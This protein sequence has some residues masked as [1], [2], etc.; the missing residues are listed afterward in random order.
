MGKLLIT[1]GAVTTASRLARMALRTGVK[2][3]VIQTPSFLNSGGCSY[4]I[5]INES[6]FDELD[7]VSKKYN[8]PYRKIYL[9]DGGDYHALPR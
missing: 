4:S 6:D 2:A 8:I 3:S 7:I 9:I 1:V 5:K